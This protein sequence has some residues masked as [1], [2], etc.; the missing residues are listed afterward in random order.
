MMNKNDTPFLQEVAQQPAA[1][2]DLIAYYRGAGSSRL[3]HWAERAKKAG[4]IL[5]TGM[6]TSEFAPETALTRMTHSGLHTA[7]ADAG[8]LLHYPRPINGMLV[9]ISQSGESVE[10]RKLAASLHGNGSLAAI[11]NNEDS[12]VAQAAEL[13][14]P[15]LAGDETAISTKTYVNTLAVLYLMAQALIGPQDVEHGLERLEELAGAMDDYDG[16]AIKQAARFIADRDAIH[17]ISRGPAMVAAKQSALTFMEGTGVSATALTGGAFRHGPFELVGPDYRCVMFIPGGPTG[18][19]LKVMAG[20]VAEKGSHVVVIT[21]QENFRLH[22]QRCAVLHVPTFGEEL[23]AIA[24]ATTQE[25]LLD[26]VASERGVCAG[27]FRY[28]QKITARE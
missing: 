4:R 3:E 25:L 12:T 2:R 27:E 26:A 13:L 17:F 6:G 20:E 1:M 15:M 22:E 14:L 16:D 7:T 18:D 8:E 11:V 23:F 10:T 24:A 19:L 28:C 21:D 9:L 5:F